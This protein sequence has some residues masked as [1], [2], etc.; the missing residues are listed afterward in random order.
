MDNRSYNPND[1]NYFENFCSAC[2]NFGTC[3]CLF[4]DYVEENTKWQEINCRN[5]WN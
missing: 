2:D 3:N 1:E 5:F 4:M